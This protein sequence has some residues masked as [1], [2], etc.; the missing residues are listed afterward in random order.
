MCENILL[1]SLKYI[2]IN[3]KYIHLKL[4]LTCLVTVFCKSK[5]NYFS[6]NNNVDTDRH[7]CSHKVRIYLRTPILMRMRIRMRTGLFPTFSIIL[8]MAESRKHLGCPTEYTHTHTEFCGDSRED[9]FIFLPSLLSSDLLII[10]YGGI[11]LYALAIL[12]H[13]S[14]SAWQGNLVPIHYI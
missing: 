5:K 9:S 8:W 13:Y 4:N 2:Q 3:L 10:T 1:Q 6:C 7:A 12:S 14:L 11:I